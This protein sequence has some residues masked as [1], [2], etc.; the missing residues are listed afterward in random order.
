MPPLDSRRVRLAAVRAGGRL[1]AIRG[2][3]VDGRTLMVHCELP[4]PEGLSAAAVEVA[5]GVRADP[6][7]NP[8]R[9]LWAGCAARSEEFGALPD[10]ERVLVVRTSSAGDFSEYEVGVTDPARWGFDPR[11]ADLP[12]SFK[13]DCPAEF[14]PRPPRATVSETGPPPAGDYLDRDFAG[15]RRLLLDRLSLLLPGWSDRNP[16]DV[17]VT[18][19]ELVA[20]LGDHLAYAQDSA[21][22]EAYLG[23]A[24]QR[25]SVRR[26]ARLLDYRMHDGS[27]ARTW[28]ALTVA[29]AADGVTLP[30]G[31]E[32]CSAEQP[33]IVFHTFHPHTARTAR[34]AMALHDWGD[35]RAVLPAGATEATLLGSGS[36]LAAG[37]VLMLESGPA[38]RH[39]VRLTGPPEPV[40]DPLDDRE[41]VRVRWHPAD[42]TPG[43]MPL[44]ATVARGNVVLAGHGEL[45]GPEPLVPATVPRQGRY[46]PR[47]SRPG[48]T[49]AAGY[50]HRQAL[51]RPAADALRTTLVDA[52]PAVLE[53]HDGTT[54]WT[55]ARDLL[56]AGRFEPR[57]VVETD[58]ESSAWLRFGDGQGGRL[59]A[60][61]SRFTATY[62][63][64]GGSAGNVGREALTRLR[65]AVPGVD[66][67]NPLPATGGADP[68][69]VERVRQWAPARLSVVERAV[70]NRDHAELA[71][72]HP[73]VRQAVSGRR[74]TGSW[75]TDVVSVQ[76]AAG[77]ADPGLL[78][79]VAAHLEGYRMAG[80][81][82]RVAPAVG[83]PLDIVL[84]VHLRGGYV[85]A[86]VKR[87]LAV[88]FSAAPGGFFDPG[89]FG[90]GEPVV[91]SRVIAAA[92]G[93]PGVAR[94]ETGP[95]GG[96]RFQRW[97]RPV[98]GE[99]A[100]GRI[101]IGASEVARCLSDPSLPEHGRIDFVT[102]AA[103]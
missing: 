78:A 3:E 6:A 38:L 13:V 82:L 31:T 30:A 22:T 102:V 79:S 81:D 85:P 50:D 48:L 2:L 101:P 9:V 18:L 99:W 7:I 19:V 53:V 57:Y 97:G 37:D 89:A 70:T 4:V 54:T 63:V 5:G 12:F 86:D 71:A 95:G 36:G 76:P 103:G 32:V 66:V 87:A 94:V 64:G 45:A 11:L 58:D 44:G 55:V 16:A 68:E 56:D 91:L 42:A 83:V 74:W 10:A 39:P 24:R 51:H 29:P 47:L 96:H 40:T 26:H 14:D 90:F 88:R 15:L 80:G 100:A 23:T 8:V 93:V 65:S 60:P 27:A 34:N 1:N 49:Y 21:A 62:R 75:H 72:R 77:P 33:P 41:L 59:P 92:M 43:P 73:G 67:R 28:L 20:L 46:R 25:I 17:G 98:A 69:A 52:A 35:E 84:T 61:G